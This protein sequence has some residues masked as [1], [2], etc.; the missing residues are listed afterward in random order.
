MFGYT[1]IDQWKYHI[2]KC[3]ISR[4]EV[5][6]LKDKPDFLIPDHRQFII[7]HLTD[8]DA[9]QKIM[10]AGRW[11]IQSTKKMFIEVDFPSQ[12]AP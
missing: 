5:E 11:L 7:Y 4:K 10:A 9:I 8:I 1:P 3:I 2:F 12:K 6:G